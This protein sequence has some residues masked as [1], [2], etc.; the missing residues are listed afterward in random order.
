MPIPTTQ[1]QKPKTKD[2][3]PARAFHVFEMFEMF[4]LF[5]VFPLFEMFALFPRTRNARK[6]TKHARMCDLESGFP[7][8]KPASRLRRRF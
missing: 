7:A 5:E 4:E 6:K 3:R 2:Q 1:A 8:D